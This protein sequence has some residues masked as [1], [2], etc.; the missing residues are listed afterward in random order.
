MDRD[1]VSSISLFLVSVVVSKLWSRKEEPSELTTTRV[2]KVCQ[3]A[4][5]V[6]GHGDDLW[7]HQSHPLMM[8][9]SSNSKVVWDPGM[10]EGPTTVTTDEGGEPVPSYYVRRMED[11]MSYHNFDFIGEDLRQQL[12]S[13]HAVEDE[14]YET[15]KTDIKRQSR[16]SSHEELKDFLPT[17][18]NWSHFDFSSTATATVSSSNTNGA[19]AV[20]N[21]HGPHQHDKT[22]NLEDLKP[23]ISKYA[24]KDLMKRQ[25]SL[26]G[27]ESEAARSTSSSQFIWTDVDSVQRNQKAMAQRQQPFFDQQNSRQSSESNGSLP[28]IHS[29]R[30]MRHP[31]QGTGSTFEPFD[32]L[33]EVRK[34]DTNHSSLPRPQFGRAESLDDRTMFGHLRDNEEDDFESSEAEDNGDEDD[35]FKGSL[36]HTPTI[37]NQKQTDRGRTLNGKSDNDGSKNDKR[38]KRKASSS[39]S[40]ASSA[41]SRRSYSQP[42]LH[43]HDDQHLHNRH[44]GQRSIRDYD[45]SLSNTVRR[46]NRVARSHYN[47]RIM[48]NTVGKILTLFFFSLWPP[49]TS[50]TFHSNQFDTVFCIN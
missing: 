47:A 20:S 21:N 46:Q 42:D 18:R 36:T 27:D 19:S 35:F 16:R 9:K 29:E 7:A 32:P 44:R 43:Q 4:L 8:K 39:Q 33:L 49:L 3:D 24:G 50:L 31:A 22:R 48:P 38:V 2:C 12:A 13:D 30:E 17:N 37:S 1:V 11:R 28:T 10:G 15:P 34:S 41:F 6:D 45:R 14:L 26:E 23:L 25:V 5:R 40:T